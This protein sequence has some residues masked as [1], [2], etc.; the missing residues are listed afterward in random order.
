M[1]TLR[2]AM[3]C[4]FAVLNWSAGKQTMVSTRFGS[5]ESTAFLRCC[6]SK[7]KANNG[8]ELQM[9]MQHRKS[10]RLTTNGSSGRRPA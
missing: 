9:V 1:G 3:N 10:W 2:V 5:L 8:A 4:F 6:Q 7:F